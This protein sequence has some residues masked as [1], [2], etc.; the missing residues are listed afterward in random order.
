[1]ERWTHRPREAEAGRHGRGDLYQAKAAMWWGWGAS[2]GG[3]RA[4]L[5]QPLPVGR[6]WRVGSAWI[7]RQAAQPA[8]SSGLS[9]K[10]SEAADY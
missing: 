1:M 7:H 3:D 2:A 6:F 8:P 4:W 5:R 10:H 9:L